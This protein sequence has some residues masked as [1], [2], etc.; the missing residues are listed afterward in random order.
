MCAHLATLLHVGRPPQWARPDTPAPSSE[1]PSSGGRKLGA[2]RQATGRPGGHHGA[3]DGIQRRASLCSPRHQAVMRCE[4]PSAMFNESIMVVDGGGARAT[5]SL[6]RPIGP[7]APA[8]GWRHLARARPNN[9]P[10]AWH[11]IR[12]RGPTV[13]ERPAR[14]YPSGGGV[15]GCGGPG[16]GRRRAPPERLAKCKCD[17]RKPLSDLAATPTAGPPPQAKTENLKNDCLR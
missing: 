5:M 7:G 1:D 3:P 11:C 13:G 8:G 10:V 15:P 16:S 14:N 12:H 2:R 6:G 4:R 9:G 17:V